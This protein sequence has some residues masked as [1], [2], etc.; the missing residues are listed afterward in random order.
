MYLMALQDMASSP[1]RVV[2]EINQGMDQTNERLVFDRIVQS[3]CKDAQ[4]G[5]GRPQYFLV[6]PKLLQGLRAMDND[7]VT[8]LLVF[9]GPG[10]GSKWQLSQ[11]I[12][13]LRDQEEKGGSSSSKRVVEETTSTT[14]SRKRTRL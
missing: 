11:V 9:N 6:T 13:R 1:F 10:V 2:D 5:L 7:N 4:E 3:C 12:K 14:T 8:V